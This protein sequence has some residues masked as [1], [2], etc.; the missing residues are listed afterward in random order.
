VT[1]CHRLVIS[2]WTPFSVDFLDTAQRDREVDAL[3]EEGY[4]R[5][6][7][8]LAKKASAN[9]GQKRL[10]LGGNT[11][12][13]AGDPPRQRIAVSVFESMDKAQ[14]AYTSPDFL[15]AQKAGERYAKLPIF[16]V[17]AE[18]PWSALNGLVDRAL[19]KTVKYRWLK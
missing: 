19:H 15:E 16:A 6:Y 2:A 13:I 4:N 5:E 8:P 14:A 10:A 12:T 1:D 9:S 18:A 3:N 7:I 11:L 17:E